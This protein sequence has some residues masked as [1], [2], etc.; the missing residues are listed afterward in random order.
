MKKVTKSNCH[1]EINQLEECL[2]LIIT[3]VMHHVNASCLQWRHSGVQDF[4]VRFLMR[5]SYS[6][7]AHNSLQ[8]RLQ[9]L[10]QT[11]RYNKEPY[12]ASQLAARVHMHSPGFYRSIPRCLLLKK[13]P[14]LHEHKIRCSGVI[15]S[16]TRKKITT[17]CFRQLLKPLQRDPQ[18]IV[19]S[20]ERLSRTLQTYTA[21]RRITG[22]GLS[23]VG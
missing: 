22:L 4:S 16:E 6:S 17:L 11:E 1:K 5:W 21:T 20:D 10:E 15:L 8:N 12:Y 23:H 3:F 14:V 18:F 9:N 7:D 13:M 2:H 19:L